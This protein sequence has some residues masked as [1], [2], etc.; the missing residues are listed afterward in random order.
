LVNLTSTFVKIYKVV[1]STAAENEKMFA[2][3][4]TLKRR[5]L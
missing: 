1:F 5:S 2:R 4:F 3:I